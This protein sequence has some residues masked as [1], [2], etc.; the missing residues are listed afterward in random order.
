LDERP[1]LT[2]FLPARIEWHGA[3]PQV[4]ALKWQGSGDIAALAGANCFLVVPAERE[5]I[6]SGERVSVL[7]RVDVV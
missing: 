4:S 7:L 5:K 3:E 2:H 1:G 6:A